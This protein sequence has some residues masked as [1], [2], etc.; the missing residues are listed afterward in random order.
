M[1]I[2]LNYKTLL[3]MFNRG[4]FNQ[5]LQKADRYIALFPNDVK[6]LLVI[7][8][9]YFAKHFF[10]K[11]LDVYKT[12]LEVLPA[13]DKKFRAEI[14]YNI[15]CIYAKNHEHRSA[16]NHFLAS[17]SICD[18]F[19]LNYVTLSLSLKNLQKYR[20][21]KKILFD[22]IVK[23]PNSS[24]IKYN[25]AN[26]LQDF[27]DFAQALSLYREVLNIE[28]NHS[29][30]HYEYSRLRV[31]L[32]KDRHIPEMQKALKNTKSPEDLS[33]LSFGLG[34]AYA[35]LKSYNKAF[36]YWAEGNA[37]FRSK[38]N[39]D[40]KR[41]EEQFE[42]FKSWH[43][44]IHQDSNTCDA[45]ICFIIG[46]PRSGT[47]L[48]EQILS[49]HSQIYG[50]G[51]LTF[52]EEAILKYH[53]SNQF[54]PDFVKV[55]QH[56]T[57][58]IREITRTKKMITDKNPLNFRWVGMIKSCF[59]NSKIIH[60]YRNPK[61]VCFSIFKHLFPSGCYFSS[62]IDEIFTYYDL[63]QKHMNHWN[64]LYDDII[65]V[66]YENLTKQPEEEVKK[67][68]A[69]C[70]LNFEQQCMDIESNTR[71]VQ[72]ITNSQIRASIKQASDETKNYPQYNKAYDLKFGL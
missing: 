21:A 40:I 29:K 7:G 56:Y 38:I 32:A 55:R 71:V 16:L 39:F 52:L 59:P 67:L 23:F 8:K 33:Y 48:I 37:H 54:A 47:S 60:V 24:V 6:I 1:L 3:Q 68:L 50:A 14:E 27:G 70:D 5:I 69:A 11:A 25:L 34:N 58:R 15:G 63:Y 53:E 44:N 10:D 62:N 41:E 12:I 42:L 28:N 17:K 9:T 30:A 31:Y 20:F 61:S 66:S 26:L 18:D 49:G 4:E 57:K 13:D 36:T 64:V 43:K 35:N 45:R 72:T 65:N 2:P 51:E 19:E 22:G 46:T